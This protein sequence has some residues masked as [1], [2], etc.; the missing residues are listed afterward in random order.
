[1]SQ[2]EVSFSRSAQGEGPLRSAVYRIASVA[3]CHLDIVDER[4]I[5]GL[6]PSKEAAR[7]G[8]DGEGLRAHFLALVNDENLRERIA[9]QTEALRNV[10]VSLAFGALARRDT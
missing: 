9:G 10:I 4:W 8:V 5:C 7:Q 6:T 3:S 2:I 1:M